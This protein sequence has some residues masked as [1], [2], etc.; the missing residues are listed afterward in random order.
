MATDSGAS[1]WYDDAMR[2]IIDLT[3]EQIEQLRSYCECEGVSRAEAV[4]RGVDLL[5]ARDREART[6]RLAQRR[7]ALAATFGMWKDRGI[8]AVDFQRTLRAE[9]DR[10]VWQS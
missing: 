6:L 8:D 4:R 1:S 5:L 9:W 7:S 10:D 2:T 3:D